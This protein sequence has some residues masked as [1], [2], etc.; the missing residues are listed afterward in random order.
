MDLI[1]SIDSPVNQ[2]LK[3]VDKTKIDQFLRQNSLPFLHIWVFEK[4]FSWLHGLRI[5]PNYN[6][7]RVRKVFIKE[8]KKVK[9]T[10][11]TCFDLVRFGWV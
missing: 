10:N 5:K 8:E 2:K 4:R 6:T 7:D 11:L 3:R 9:K 1:E